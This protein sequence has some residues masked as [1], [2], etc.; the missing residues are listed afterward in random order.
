MLD[1]YRPIIYKTTDNGKSWN[2]VDK[3]FP[4]DE[5]TR[6]LRV[7]K[8]NSNILYV[9]TETGLFVSF[10]DA[11]SW[12]KLDSN[13]PVVPIY[14]IDIKDNNMV[15]ATHGRS[16]WILDDITAISQLND[17]IDDNN[18]ILKPAPTYRILPPFGFRLFGTGPD[19]GK[20]YSASLGSPVL[21]EKSKNPDGEVSVDYLDSGENPPMGVPIYFYLDNEVDQAELIIKDNKGKILKSFSNENKNDKNTKVTKSFLPS[22]KENKFNPKKG[23]N[24]F[25]WDMY[26]E[27]PYK[28]EGEKLT[29]GLSGPMALPGI[30]TVEI[31]TSK[32]KKSNT[33][34][35]EI[36]LIKDPRV[37]ASAKDFEDQFNLIQQVNQKLSELHKSVEVIR[38]NQSEISD[39]ISRS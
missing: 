5:I 17:N 10:D 6:V 23:F 33:L 3:S 26:C 4:Q 14:D 29:E 2:R 39:W 12:S 32:K 28:L 35:T 18:F 20:S 25:I 16:F 22:K 24:T 11:K 34:K 8:N 31:I 21:I 15:L 9:G 1:D 27:G 30:Y 38:Q 19:N 37:S 13:L 7:D 36:T